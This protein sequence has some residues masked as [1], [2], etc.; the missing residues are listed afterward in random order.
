VDTISL[1][2]I[3]NF[4]DTSLYI[5]MLNLA[6]T[7]SSITPFKHVRPDSD[8]SS[9][10]FN[11]IRSGTY[12]IFAAADTTITFNLDSLSVYGGKIYT[13]YITGNT[14]TTDPGALRRGLIE[15]N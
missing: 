12:Q 5:A 2:R 6:D 11:K 1:V 14:K 9:F 10:V 3:L 13:V 15:H 4:C 8:P 7:I